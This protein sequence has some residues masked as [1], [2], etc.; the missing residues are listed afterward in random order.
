MYMLQT[1][2]FSQEGK[3]FPCL[4]VFDNRHMVAI[5]AMAASLSQCGKD[6]LRMPA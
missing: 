2:A 5:E 1:T 3:R 6:V 4:V